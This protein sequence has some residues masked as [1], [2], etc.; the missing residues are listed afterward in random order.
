MDQNYPQARSRR[1]PAWRE[2]CGVWPMSVWWR[3]VRAACIASVIVAGS[4]A[5]CA[6]QVARVA[7]SELQPPAAF[8][9]ASYR[10]AAARGQP[11]FEIDAARSQ[12]VI[13]VRRAGTLAQLGHDHVIASHDVHGFLAPD[14]RRADLYLPLDRLA[15]DEH[16]LRAESGFEGEPPEAAIAGTRENMLSRFHV[17]Q[18]PNALIAVRRVDAGETGVELDVSITLNGATRTTQILAQIERTGNEMSV[19]GHLDVRQTEFGIAPYS[20]LGGALQVDDKVAI[21]FEIV[22]RRV[23]S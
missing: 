13:E 12:V 22:A 15:V 7:E 3:D 17:D 20:I 11:V 10:Q 1:L 21:R 2:R 8:P 5:G 4:L 16:A 6:P 18:Y 9:D 19:T 23:R 14:E